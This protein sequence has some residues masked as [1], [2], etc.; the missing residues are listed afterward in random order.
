MRHLHPQDLAKHL[1]QNRQQ[2]LTKTSI[3][4]YNSFVTKLRPW[5]NYQ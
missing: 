1:F 3:A 5:G 2:Q 4:A